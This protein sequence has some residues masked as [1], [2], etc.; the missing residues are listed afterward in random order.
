MA[1]GSEPA[2]Y[3]SNYSIIAKDLLFVFGMVEWWDFQTVNLKITIQA[4]VEKIAI[5][6]SG[7]INTNLID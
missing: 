2:N 7:K 1:I 3:E 4:I 5:N 6:R